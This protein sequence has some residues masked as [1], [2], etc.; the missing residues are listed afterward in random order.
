M[1]LAEQIFN[2]REF[3]PVFEECQSLD[4]VTDCLYEMKLDLSDIEYEEVIASVA[5]LHF[6]V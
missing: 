1:T 4:E 2:N 5:N 6:T 3:L